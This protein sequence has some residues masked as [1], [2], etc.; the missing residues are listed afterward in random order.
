MS[1]SM[2]GNIRKLYYRFFIQHGSENI[3]FKISRL[4]DKAVK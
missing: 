1:L 4:V 3:A 2:E